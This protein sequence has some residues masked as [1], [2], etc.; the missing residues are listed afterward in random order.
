MVNMKLKKAICCW[1]CDN[2][3]TFNIINEC[4]ERFRAY[5]Y[6]DKGAFLIGGDEVHDFIVRASD[7]IKL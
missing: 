4:V 1:L 3:G 6:D 5:V 2:A 7:L